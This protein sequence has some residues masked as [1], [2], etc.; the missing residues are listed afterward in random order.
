MM[1]VMPDRVEL[2]QD[3]Q[4]LVDLAARQAGHRLVGDQQP[5]PRRHG[6]RQL[7]LAQLDLRQLLDGA[8]RLVGE[9][10]L[11]EDLHRLAACLRVVQRGDAT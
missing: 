2:E 3:R 8:S 7:E 4:H 10:D 5:R 1:M 9:A 6:A 11:L